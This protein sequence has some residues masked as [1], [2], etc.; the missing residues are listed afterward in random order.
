MTKLEKD[1]KNTF[2]EKYDKV[3]KSTLGISKAIA[4]VAHKSQ[5][6]LNNEPYFNHP[7]NMID[8]YAELLQFSNEN[9]SLDNVVIHGIPFFGVMELCYLHDVIED[10]E[11]TFED[12]KAIFDKHGYLNEFNGDLATS[13]VLITHDKS[14]SYDIYVNKC[15][16]NIVSALVKFLDMI[17]NLNLFTLDKFEDQE[18]ERIVKYNNCLKIINDKFHFIEK[19]SNYNRMMKYL[20]YEKRKREEAKENK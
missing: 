12:I 14:E 11:Y 13:L 8:K 5:F 10:T 16:E 17:D 7:A 20:A 4:F 9:F 15:C 19:F 3:M 1:L 18:L 2:K 6:R